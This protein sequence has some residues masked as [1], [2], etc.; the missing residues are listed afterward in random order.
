MSGCMLWV[1]GWI[2]RTVVHA[3][4]G[5]RAGQVL[6]ERAALRMA[7]HVRGIYKLSFE[8]TGI[9]KTKAKEMQNQLRTSCELPLQRDQM[10]AD[11]LSANLNTF[12]D[13]VLWK[14]P[15]QLLLPTLTLL[16]NTLFPAKEYDSSRRTPLGGPMI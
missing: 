5:S 15:L 6:I 12:T 4:C 11:L 2:R 7:K 16:C 10:S 9:N 14:T 8:T 13:L 1:R 3:Q